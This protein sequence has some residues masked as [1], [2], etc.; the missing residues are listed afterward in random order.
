[1]SLTSCIEKIHASEGY[2][3]SFYRKFFVSQYGKTSWGNPSVLCFRKFP[4]AKFIDKRGG[5]GY[6][7]FPSKIFCLTVL[8]NFV[9]EPFCVS[10]V[11]W[12]RKMLGIRGGG[13]HDFPSKMFCLTVPNH[14]VEEPFCVSESFGNQKILSLRGE[15]HDF[16]R[17]FVVSQYQK[18]LRR[19]TLLCFKKFLVSKKVMHKREGEE[20]GSITTFCR[21]VFVSQ[22][23]KIS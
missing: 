5:G 21:E 16:Y 8:K 4:V 14:F 1:M 18:K 13:H 9:E 3:T 19:R 10:Q 17:N 7:H 22:C 15:N 23:R 20:K 11:F 2:I 6:Q 12:Y